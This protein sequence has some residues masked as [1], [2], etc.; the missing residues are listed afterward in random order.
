LTMVPGTPLFEGITGG[1]IT[2]GPCAYAVRLKIAN[3]EL[4]NVAFVVLRD[5][6]MDL[7]EKPP[8]HQRGVIGIAHS[9][10]H[11]FGAMES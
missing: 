1:R 4:R 6:T 3:T 10:R 7:F 5:S 2:Q 9:A 8:Q 11:R